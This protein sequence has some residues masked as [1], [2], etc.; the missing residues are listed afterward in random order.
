M[1]LPSLEE[2]AYQEM[3]ERGFEANFPKE[4]LEET[5]KMKEFSYRNSVKDL[6]HIP[7]FSIDNETSEDLDQLTYAEPLSQTTFK[8]VVAIADVDSLVKIG[9]ATDDY[10]S[11]NTTSVYTPTKIFTMLP[12]K[13]SNGLTSLLPNKERIALI[14]E[15]EI[16]EIGEPSFLDIYY[17]WVNNH[18]KLVY[19]TVAPFL[20]NCIELPIEKTIADQLLMQDKIAQLIKQYRLKRGALELETPDAFP[21]IHR[22]QVVA[23]VK[24]EPNRARELIEN[25]MIAANL[26]CNHFLKESGYPRICRIVKTPKNWPRI[27]E[28]AKERNFAL[29]N[30]PDPFTLNQF[31]KKMQTEDP[32]SYPD[33]SLAVIKLMGRGEYTAILNGNEETEHFGLSLKDY[34]HATAPNRRYVDL[35]MGRLIK[36]ALYKKPSPYSLDKLQKIALQCSQK[37]ADADKVERKLN[38]CAIARLFV[39]RIGENFRAIVTGASERGTWVRILAIPIEGKLVKFKSKAAVGDKMSVKLLHVDP[40]EGFIDFAEI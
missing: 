27:V 9:S 36:A 33:L 38:K 19:D 22:Q 8:A 23:A 26:S 12:P 21:V 3:E 37:E 17:G 34:T 20:E 4:V 11:F 1:N 18:A 30:A 40:L 25:F 35:I 31:L 16:N 6:R 15:I 7:F 28:L 14:I 24:E 2:I 5:D 13:L 29:P 10:A 39:N 32:I